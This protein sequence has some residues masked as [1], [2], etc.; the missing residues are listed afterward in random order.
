MKRILPVLLAVMLVF[1][2]AGQASAYFESGNLIGVVYGYDAGEGAMAQ[3]LL[4]LGDMDNPTT[5]S[6]D[7]GSM[8]LDIAWAGVMGYD[9]MTSNITLGIAGNETPALNASQFF[10]FDTA[11]V[12]SINPFAGSGTSVI[13][14]STGDSRAYL[15]HYDGAPDLS[16]PVALDP[17]GNFAG[18][19]TTGDNTINLAGIDM[20]DAYLRLMVTDFN[21]GP[22]TEAAVSPIKISAEGSIVTF[23]PVPVPAAVWL[24]G[25]GLVGLLGIRRKVA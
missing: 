3:Y 21:L 9:L 23:T 22:L 1:G 6:V 18:L 7:I 10:P 15:T 5:N 24:L 16:S 8:G 4:D 25:S 19:T 17:A 14:G 13:E 20:E 12:N 2:M 11:Y